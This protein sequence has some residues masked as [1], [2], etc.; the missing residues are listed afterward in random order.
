M[1]PSESDDD[2]SENDSSSSDSENNEMEPEGSPVNPESHPHPMADIEQPE[3]P[4]SPSRPPSE[5]S[6]QQEDLMDLDD[7][8]ASDPEYNSTGYPGYFNVL[9]PDE[10]DDED[11]SGWRGFD[12]L[13][14][15]DTPD[16]SREEMIA[17]LEQM[18]GPDDDAELWSM[19]ASAEG[20]FK[21]VN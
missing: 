4:E 13:Q 10:D 1:L 3:N 6:E 7:P 20:P 12:E 9:A 2:E 8:L 17:Q 11:L 16:P 15:A 5:F 19:H 21:L 18:L 14:D